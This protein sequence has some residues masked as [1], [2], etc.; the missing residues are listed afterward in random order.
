MN[1][2]SPFDDELAQSTRKEVAARKCK[3]EGC[4][5]LRRYDRGLYGGLCEKCAEEK[6]GSP[7]KKK[8]LPPSSSPSGSDVNLEQIIA[9]MDLGVEMIFRIGDRRFR[10]QEVRIEDCQT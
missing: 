6:K 8:K 10:L 4:H 2:Q 1:R 9:M 5:N 7:L 3:T